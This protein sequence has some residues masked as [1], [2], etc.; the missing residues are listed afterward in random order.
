MLVHSI[1]NL[2]EIY[3]KFLTI[4]HCQKFVNAAVPESLEDYF[5]KVVLLAFGSKS[6]T[7][8][9]VRRYQIRTNCSLNFEGEGRGVRFVLLPNR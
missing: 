8:S 5:Q 9:L 3:L 4:F 6:G 2:Y 7:K 1:R